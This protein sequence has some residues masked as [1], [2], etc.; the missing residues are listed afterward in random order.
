VQLGRRKRFDDAGSF[1]SH[2]FAPSKAHG[3]VATW[4]HTEVGTSRLDG[5]LL[6]AVTPDERVNK[7]EVAP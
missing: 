1:S 7:K 5:E 6:E 4:Q 2:I 3:S